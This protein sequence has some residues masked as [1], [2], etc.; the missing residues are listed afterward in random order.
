MEL[1]V[2][3]DEVRRLVFSRLEALDGQGSAE[4][5]ELPQL[6]LRVV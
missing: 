4:P 1:C 2:E 6:T 3:A 5:V